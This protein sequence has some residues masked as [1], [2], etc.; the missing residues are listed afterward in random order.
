MK[1]TTENS[2][3]G[4]L[5]FNFKSGK[6]LICT[7]LQDASAVCYTALKYRNLMLGKH[8]SFIS[9]S[10]Y[11]QIK[12]NNILHLLIFS[13]LYFNIMKYPVQRSKKV[14]SPYH[15]TSR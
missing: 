12:N 7:T 9:H 14:I 11:I 6:T 13:T 2:D 3:D 5:E 10:I 1:L 4:S 15:M 8:P